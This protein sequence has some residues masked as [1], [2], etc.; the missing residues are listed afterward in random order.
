MHVQG[1]HKGMRMS[2]P[3]PLTPLR[4]AIVAAVLLAGGWKARSY[5]ERGRM[6]P[7]ALWDFRA[8]MSF[9]EI[10]AA[11][12]EQ[13]RQRF[14]CRVPVPG[15]RLCELHVTGIPG[16][17]RV[18]VDSLDR[19]AV[20]QFYPDSASPVMRE[21][22]RKIAAR[23][24]LVRTGAAETPDSPGAGTTTR[25]SSIDGKWFSM[26]Q[27]APDAT[28]PSVVHL[29]DVAALKSIFA[30]APFAQLVLGLN[31][32]VETE[33][34][35]G[36]RDLHAALAATMYGRPTEAT[37]V[38]VAGDVSSVPT[39]SAAPDMILEGGDMVQQSLGASATALLE[40]AIARAYPGSRAVVG[41]A[42][43]IVDPTGKAER[44]EVQL[45]Q[46]ESL[47]DVVLFALSF[48]GR[49]R[50]ASTRLEEGRAERFCRAASEVVLARRGD[51]GALAEAHRIV[52][53]EEA[54]VSDITTLSFGSPELTGEPPQI[55]LRHV[56]VYATDRWRGSVH[57][58]T[59]IDGDPPRAARRVPLTFGHRVRSGTESSEGTLVLTHRS[60]TSIELSTLEQHGWGFSTRRLSVPVDSAGALLGARILGGLQ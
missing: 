30:S 7:F 42:L 8:G 59:I 26:M 34:T 13:T 53:D 5:I 22:G 57:W 19:A 29:A 18:L 28:T 23:W 1:V 36:P 49:V 9:G 37:M 12:L 55:R 51:D 3:A 60:R 41:D 32:L 14:T 15:S 11:A 16:R 33:D 20:V 40:A 35:D 21:E 10:E 4:L 31:Q 48:P 39:C 24:S 58:E 52:A 45:G 43:W 38:P 50:E 17:V 56:G 44:A 6:S 27:Y 25:W 54:I 2:L 46:V 47:Q